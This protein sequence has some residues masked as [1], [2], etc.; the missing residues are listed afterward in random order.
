MA[1]TK[2]FAAIVAAGALLVLLAGCLPIF[3]AD[4]IDPVHKPAAMPAS[5]ASRAAH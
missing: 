1:L 5:A 2:A 4:S 3:P